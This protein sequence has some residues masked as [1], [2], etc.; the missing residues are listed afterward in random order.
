MRCPSPPDLR[1]Q[2][3]EHRTTQYTPY[4]SRKRSPKHSPPYKLC[5]LLQFWCGSAPAAW[6][7]TTGYQGGVLDRGSARATQL[8]PGGR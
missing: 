2:L 4:S 1:R 5:P 8:I 7:K 6:N 3:V